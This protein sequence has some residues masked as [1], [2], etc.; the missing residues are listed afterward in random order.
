MLPTV[1][2][3]QENADQQIDVYDDGNLHIEHDN[4][5]VSCRGEQISLSRKEFLIISR[6]VRNPGRIVTYNNIW[7]H[8]WGENSEFNSGALRVHVNHLRQKLGSYGIRIE[9]MVNV[10]YCVMLPT[11]P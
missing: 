10:G 11:E 8:A 2:R 3:L 4:Y 9:S 7:Q 1:P 5:F 6:L